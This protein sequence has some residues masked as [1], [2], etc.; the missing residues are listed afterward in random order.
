MKNFRCYRASL[1]LIS[2]FV[3]ISFS[4]QAKIWEVSVKNYSFSPFNL[5]HVKAGDTIK[6]IWESGHHSTTSVSIPEGAMSWEY[7]INPDSTNFIYI[8]TV[9]GTYSYKSAPDIVNPMTGSFVVTG[10]GGIEENPGSPLLSL[11]PNPFHDRIT[12][13]TPGGHVILRRLEITDSEGKMIQEINFSQQA[14]LIPRTLELKNL[15]KGLFF[16]KFTD[17][18]NR[19]IIRRAIHN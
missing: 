9:N 1:V 2:V 10:A 18:S 15:P 17:T 14:A 4:S 11:S 8:P 19:K 5:T 7:S 13:S 16:F 6:W 12:I 3:L